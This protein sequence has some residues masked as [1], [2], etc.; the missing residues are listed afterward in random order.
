MLTLKQADVGAREELINDQ[1]HLGLS[2]V[3]RIMC[4]NEVGMKTGL[5]D[6]GRKMSYT[7]VNAAVLS[8]LKM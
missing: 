2:A 1:Q 7:K 6:L 3:S 4:Q 8:Q 5:T